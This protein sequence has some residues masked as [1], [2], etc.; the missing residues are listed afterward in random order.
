LAFVI[1]SSPG[2]P[3]PRRH[4]HPHRTRGNDHATAF[5]A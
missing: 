2:S 3:R 5:T 1:P 4:Q